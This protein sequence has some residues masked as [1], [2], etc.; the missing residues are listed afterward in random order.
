MGGGW[1]T[2]YC[3]SCRMSVYV[4]HVHNPGVHG[5]IYGLDLEGNDRLGNKHGAA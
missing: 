2:S 4:P 1:R 3:R 5:I